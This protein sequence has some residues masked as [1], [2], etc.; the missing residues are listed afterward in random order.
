MHEE[1]PHTYDDMMT[2]P[3]LTGCV[4][5]AGK[6]QNKNFIGSG[7]VANLHVPEGDSEICASDNQIKI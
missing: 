7:V 1:V 3:T 6:K 5:M 4:D 2:D